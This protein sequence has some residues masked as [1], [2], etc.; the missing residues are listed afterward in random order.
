M[1]MYLDRKSFT[2]I[3]DMERK[4]NGGKP[5]RKERRE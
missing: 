1:H 3:M 4:Y 2:K 5:L